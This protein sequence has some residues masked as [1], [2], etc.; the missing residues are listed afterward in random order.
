MDEKNQTT[1]NSPFEIS[2]GL[3]QAQ[4]EAKSPVAPKTDAKD[5]PPLKRDK[6][7]DEP[8]FKKLRRGS[9]QFSAM[10]KEQKFTEP[11]A[12]PP[13]ANT[14]LPTQPLANTAQDLELK[15]KKFITPLKLTILILLLLAMG[16]ITVSATLVATEFTIYEPPLPI[17]NFLENIFSGKFG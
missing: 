14:P 10:P 5:L 7:A 6:K 8:F 4:N 2:A 9:D 13:V 12:T 17:K 16:L 1:P 11:P 3:K 15:P